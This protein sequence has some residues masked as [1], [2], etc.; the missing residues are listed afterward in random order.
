MTNTQSASS[1]RLRSDGAGAGPSIPPGDS[2]PVSGRAWLVVAMLFL[3]IVI[4]F[5]DKA[6]LGLAAVPIM[7]DLNLTNAQ[8]GTIGSSLFILFSISAVL[9]GFIANRVPSKHLLTIMAL[10][11]AF[12]QLPM[13]GIVS[14][15][16]LLACRIVLGAGEGPA[17]PVALHS[18][19]KWFP[20]NRRALP[21]S[22]V[23][24][25]GSVGVGIMAP[26][27]T[28]IIVT[29]SWHVAFGSLG[30]VGL[31]WVLI[32]VFVA[33]EG[34]LEGGKV[35]AGGGGMEHVPYATLL[36][37]RTAIGVFLTGIA[38][39][40]GVALSLVWLPSFLIK[41]G[42]YTP[43]E[44]S[45]IVGLPS[46]LQIFLL[47]AIGYLSQVLLTR[48]LSSRISRGFV[49]SGSVL[50]AGVALMLLSN[51][52]SAIAEGILVVIAF[53]LV[54]PIFTLGPPL[55]GEITPVHQRGAMLGINNAIFTTA[56]LVAPWAFGKIVDAAGA[57][58]ALGFRSGFFYSGMLVAVGAALGLLLINPERDLLR[59]RREGTPV[60]STQATS[61]HA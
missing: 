22:L 61:G 53:T 32:W 28:W 43:T 4:N 31:L 24:I 49:S 37:S 34:P 18:V 15:G 52:S 27:I 39:Y 42:G 13:L 46:T 30:V 1:M 60:T 3:F 7:K 2:T 35:E 29:Y 41:G 40:W 9:V 44:T 38:G 5:A 19:Y 26:L 50:V 10:I 45:F 33:K 57:D 11:W 8:F 47:P 55:I 25:G 36:F 59:F 14:F 51:S 56:G 20:D 48:G 12:T 58:A 23:Q 6:V 54:T 21:T 17:Y 16:T